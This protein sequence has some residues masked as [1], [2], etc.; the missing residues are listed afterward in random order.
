[1]VINA[2]NKTKETG[3]LPV[4]SK[5]P[6]VISSVVE[7]NVRDASGSRRVVSLARMGCL[8]IFAALVQT[9]WLYLVVSNWKDAKAWASLP[10][11]GWLTVAIWIGMIWCIPH[12]FYIGCR[13]VKF[14]RDRTAYIIQTEHDKQVMR[15]VAM[16][17]TLGVLLDFL[18]VPFI[19][20]HR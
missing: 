17:L 5:I 9:S 13:L 6:S 12:L 8:Y 19:Y 1:M 2:G 7:V 11:F 18:V 15:T 20:N 16:L 3:M 4:H 14:S 10:M